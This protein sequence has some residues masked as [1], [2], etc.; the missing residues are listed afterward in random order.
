[1][2]SLQIMDP[3]LDNDIPVVSTHTLEIFLN[4]YL[5]SRDPI[6]NLDDLQNHLDLPP[7]PTKLLTASKK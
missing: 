7:I 4:I 1:M 2:S 5:S 3:T 6:S